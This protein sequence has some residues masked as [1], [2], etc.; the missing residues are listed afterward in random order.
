MDN[1][2]RLLQ[3][4]TDRVNHPGT[5]IAEASDPAL[6]R[7]APLARVHSDR[8]DPSG[9]R[10]TEPLP[11]VHADTDLVVVILPKSVDRLDMLLAVLAGQCRNALELWLVG[12]TRDGIRGGLTRL[13]NRAESVEKLD[14]ARH[15]KLYRARVLPD[16]STGLAD[17]ASS[18]EYDGLEIISYP[19][20]F[21][22]GRLD[23]GTGELLATLEAQGEGASVLDPGCGAGV[24]SAALACAGNQV[25]AVDI[26]STAVAATRATLTANQLQADVQCGDGYAGLGC[27]D[28]IWTNPP[29]HQGNR[30]TLAV[31]EALIR[32]SPRHLHPGGTLTLV[33]NRELPYPRLLDETFKSWRILRETNRFRVYQASRN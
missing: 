27:F 24:L 11:R 18:F 21:S 23:E 12:P 6:A 19:G 14:N 17:F 26:S 30:R 33:A 13:E 4:H 2:T 16:T 22:H 7:I 3:R 15:C 1:T 25:T 8:F 32:V 31:A 10:E 28:A 20:V 9:A 5:L 29:F